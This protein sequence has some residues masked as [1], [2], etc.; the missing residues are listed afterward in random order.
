MA[1]R[2][3]E[4]RLT[5][6]YSLM[7]FL[8]FA[9]LGLPMW[10]VVRA[11]VRSA[12]DRL[13]LDRLERLVEVVAVEAERPEEVDEE[14][15]DYTAGLPERHLAEIVDAEGRRLFP[16]G[17]SPW[18]GIAT[19]ADFET[20]S[21]GGIPHRLLTRQVR[22]FDRAYTVRLGSSLESLVLIRERLVSS[23]LFAIP[24]GL[25]L[26]AGG[27]FCVARRAL[28][29]LDEI[30]ETAARIHVGS[31]SSR[32]PVPA[33]DDALERLART[34]NAML[35]RLERSVARIE[36]FSA[37]ASHELRTPLALIR[38]T[39]ELALR[40]ER[41]KEEY[42]ADLEEIHREAR[43][44][45]ELVDLLLSLSR[46]DAGEAAIER[47]EVDLS[48]IAADVANR[49]RGQAESKG[50]RLAIERPSEA[51]PVLANEPSIRRLIAS[52]LENALAH[53]REGSITVSVQDG[54]SPELRVSD[55]GEGIP[56]EALGRVFD[57][58]YR[59]DPSRSRATGGQGLGLAIARRIANLH[60]AGLDVESRV[61][62]GTRFTIRFRPRGSGT[63]RPRP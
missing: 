24:L 57:R 59:V 54:G 5:L 14:L 16:A 29:P 6:W 56:E 33:T 52:L 37:D 27:G 55:T 48:E 63:P 25:L 11:A 3:L 44:L 9:A 17:E 38:T 31:L 28:K 26:C 1:F 50:L 15:V 40:H 45:S 20:V 61:G 36:Q 60:Q 46:E 43:R 4:A 30:A 35:E 10:L 7:L 47:N 32:I 49:F 13:L 19:G 18:Q 12:A 21:R 51:V 42:R 8:G 53:T 62:E 58:F 22:I 39:A 2:S 34:F 23:L 41:T